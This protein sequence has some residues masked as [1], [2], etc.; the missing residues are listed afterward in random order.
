MHNGIAR[1]EEIFE[2]IIAQKLPNLLKNVNLR[3]LEPQWTP[4]R[5]NSKRS[6]NRHILVK[7]LK[8]NRFGENI[9][10]SKRKTNHHKGTPIKLIDFLSDRGQNTMR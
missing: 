6:T 4:S 3:I 1:R 10:I 9:K 7:L 2:E 8:I 5:I